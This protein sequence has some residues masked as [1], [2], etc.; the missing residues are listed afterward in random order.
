MSSCAVC[1]Y[2]ILESWG[3]NC[4]KNSLYR[5][6]LSV[7]TWPEENPFCTATRACEGDWRLCLKKRSAESPEQPSGDVKLSLWGCKTFACPP[8]AA[9]AT[10]SPVAARGG[11][12]LWTQLLSK[13][14]RSFWR[15]RRGILL[16]SGDEGSCFSCNW[17]LTAC[18]YKTTAFLQ[19]AVWSWNAASCFSDVRQKIC[20]K[21]I[22][23]FESRGCKTIQ[24]C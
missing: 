8:A 24:L 3:R 17:N 14:P 21:F 20:W 11:T 5:F 13:A 22:V 23:G 10:D 16:A 6:S 7:G 4:C 2:I 18:P 15:C 19:R 12:M 1:G 9:C